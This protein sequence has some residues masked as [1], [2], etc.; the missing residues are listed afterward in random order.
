[1]IVDVIMPK[2]GESITEGTIIEWKKKIGDDIAQ[3]ETILEISTDKVD[4]EVPSTHEGKLVETAKNKFVQL[5]A[6]GKKTVFEKNPAF[7]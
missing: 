3:D 6:L 2:L 4:S 1:M 5:I 7:A